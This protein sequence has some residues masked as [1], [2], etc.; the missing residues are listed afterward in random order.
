MVARQTDVGSSQ[1][2]IAALAV[3]RPL[4]RIFLSLFCLGMAQTA[5]LFLDSRLLAF[6]SG[7]AVA[8]CTMCLA[9][10]WSFRGN[11]SDIL[12][13][14]DL[15]SD[16]LIMVQKAAKQLGAKS[17]RRAM[18]VGGCVLIAGG[19]AAAVQLSG[20]VM[21]WMV[22]LG[23]LGVAEAIYAL[24]LTNHLTEQIKDW[25]DLKKIEIREA[26]ELR[27]HVARLQNSVALSGWQAAKDESAKTA[28]GELKPFH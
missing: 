23:G 13:S 11:A 17:I 4:S 12:S 27:E 6:V 20:Y 22:L 24:W 25:R 9:A 26:Y 15:N 16:D 1:G 28:S 21:Q 8:V 2:V 3:P 5:W 18:W 14:D 10:V 7:Q 19:P